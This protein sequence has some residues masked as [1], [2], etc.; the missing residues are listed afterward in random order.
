MLRNSKFSIIAVTTYLLV[1]CVLLQIERTQSVAVLMF[2]ISPVPLI[3]MVYTILKYGKYNG[4]ELAENEEY[5][6]Q[7]RR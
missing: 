4:R 3:W 2:V 5:G 6:Y 7:D 1:Y